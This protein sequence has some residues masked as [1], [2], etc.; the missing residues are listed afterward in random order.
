MSQGDKQ[1]CDVEHIV[2]RLTGARVVERHGWA[3]IAEW[4]MMHHYPQ[5]NRAEVHDMDPEDVLAALEV[6][7]E[8]KLADSGL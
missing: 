2:R 1:V 5:L 4:L 8:S 3:R 6:V 7:L